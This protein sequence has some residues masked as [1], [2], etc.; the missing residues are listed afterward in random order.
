MKWTRCGSV[1]AMSL[2]L[3]LSACKKGEDG[4]PGSQILSGSGVPA[5][6]LGNSGDYYLDKSTGA[7]FGPKTADGW[8]EATSLT[9]PKGATG[10]TGATGP[11]GANGATGATGATGAQGPAGTANVVYSAWQYANSFADSIIDNSQVKV[12]Y[13]KAPSLTTTILN[14]GT[15]LVYFTYGGGVMPLPYTSNAGGKPNTIS[16]IPGLNKITFTRFTHDNS[17]SVNLST[18]LQYR[19]ILIPGG[20][21]AARMADN[22]RQATPDYSN[23]EAVCAYYH[24]PL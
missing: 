3:L 18:V 16:F 19:Y 1:I 5:A 14:S 20:A 15:V 4:A 7:L 9:G 17:N 8:G 12:G 24:L 11:K 21:V 22:S 23:Y 6:S 2:L 13:V 10:A